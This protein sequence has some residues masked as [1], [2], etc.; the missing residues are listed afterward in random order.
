MFNA[1][2]T[3]IAP[4]SGDDIDNCLVGKMLCES[5][6]EVAGKICR[7]NNR[8]CAAPGNLTRE[9]SIDDVAAILK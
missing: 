8:A 5:L 3:I 1:S 7:F 9:R 6:V 2:L 4:P